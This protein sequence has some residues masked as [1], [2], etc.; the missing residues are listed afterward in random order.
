MS[1]TIIRL[2]LGGVLLLITTACAPQSTT[3]TIPANVESLEV[4]SS[5]TGN[6][7]SQSPDAKPLVTV[8]RSPT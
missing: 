5:D 2:A 3:E 7:E 4:A 8:S 6:A 1:R